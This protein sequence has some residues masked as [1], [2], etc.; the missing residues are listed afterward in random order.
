MQIIYIK[1]MRKILKSP[2][3]VSTAGRCKK[4]ENI[5]WNKKKVVSLQREVICMAVESNFGVKTPS[6]VSDKRSKTDVARRVVMGATRHPIKP[7]ALSGTPFP[8]SV[9]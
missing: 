3:R 2:Q 1:K 6:R 4:Y 5:W 8:A 9:K 7:R